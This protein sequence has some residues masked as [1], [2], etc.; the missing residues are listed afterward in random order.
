MNYTSTTTTPPSVNTS[1]SED[2]VDEELIERCGTAKA[3]DLLLFR[4]FGQNFSA[5]MSSK[6]L[7]LGT[8]DEQYYKIW[9]GAQWWC[10]GTVA[11]RLCGF[12]FLGCFYNF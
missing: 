7:G 1:P 5:R 12:L 3:R 11:S 8:V 2:P 9:S 4:K 10:E 6:S